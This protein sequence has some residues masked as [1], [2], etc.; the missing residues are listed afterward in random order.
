MSEPT[1]AT[2]SAAAPSGLPT[3]PSPGN[4]ALVFDGVQIRYA[5]RA[6]LAVAGVTLRA[7]YGAVTAVTGPNGSGKSTLVRAL[8]RR[9]PLVSG[10]I[11]IDGAVLSSVPARVAARRVAVVPQREDLAF[12]LTV[13]EYVALGRFPPASVWSRT[14]AEDRT[15]IDGAVGRT[16]IGDLWSRRTD[17]LS[18]GEW[19]R[20][21]IARALAQGGDTVVLDEPTTF[22]DVGHEMAVF[23]LLADLAA[24][25]MAVLLITHQ[26]NLV[27]RFAQTVVLLHRGVVAA[28]GSPRDVMVGPTLERVYDWPLVV[29][30]DPA[31][32]APML[33]P[34][35]ARD[36]SR[37]PSGPVT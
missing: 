37:S 23:E 25:G 29:G 17:E 13:R 1:R 32:G 36:V 3:R 22:L 12:P 16:G 21:R 15:A 26:L 24:S 28:V 20:V 30:Q 27:A 33:I 4:A 18:G 19:Q 8:L 6:T 31:V 9:V 2:A 11:L 5:S 35:R 10:Q 34:L 14:T 7:D